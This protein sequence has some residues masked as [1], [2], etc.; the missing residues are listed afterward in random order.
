MTLNQAQLLIHHV[1]SLTY[2]L[3]GSPR[4]WVVVGVTA[5]KKI[6]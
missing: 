2:L 4:A 1:L 5:E 3:L 6:R